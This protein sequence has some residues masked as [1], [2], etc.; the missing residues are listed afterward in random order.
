MSTG[1]SKSGKAVIV[2]TAPKDIGFAGTDDLT[3]QE[4]TPSNT[5]PQRSLAY[6]SDMTRGERREQKQDRA[7]AKRRRASNFKAL[8]VLIDASARRNR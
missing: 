2:R 6:V 1:I 3:L 8:R 4:R 5:I 7:V